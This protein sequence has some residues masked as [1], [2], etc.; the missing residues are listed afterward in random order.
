MVDQVRDRLRAKY[1]RHI[2]SRRSNNNQNGNNNNEEG[3][4]TASD[5]FKG[6]CNRCGKYGHKEFECRTKKKDH[7]QCYHCKEM[8]HYQ[9]ECPKKHN[10]NDQGSETAATAIQEEMVLVSFQKSDD[11]TGKPSPHTFLADSGASGHMINDDDGMY[12][13]KPVKINITIGD[14][15]QLTCTKIGNKKYTVKGREKDEVIVLKDV[16]FVPGLYVNLFS[17]GRALQHGWS[18]GNQGKVIFI[19]KDRN[20]IRFNKVYHTQTGFLNGIELEPLQKDGQQ[21]P[22]QEQQETQRSQQETG[23]LSEKG[24]K[25]PKI[26]LN[27]LHKTLDHVHKEVCK[28]TARYYGWELSA[29]DMEVCEPC[30]QAKAKQASLNKE[31]KTKAKQVG[32]RMCLDIQP[33]T[34]PSYGGAKNWLLVVDEK[35][36]FCWSFFIKTKDQTTKCV[37]PLLMD[38]RARNGITVKTIRCDNSGEN[39]ALLAECKAQG[40]GIQPEWTASGTPQQ[41]GKVERKLATLAGYARAMLNDA[42]IKGKMRHGL[43]AEAA[44]TAT[45]LNNILVKEEGRKSPHFQV[46]NSEAKYVNNLRQFGEL[47]VVTNRK[48]TIQ[49]KTENKGRTCM[50]V[51]YPSDSP[52]KTFRMFDFAKGSI[53][54]SRD[55]TWLNRTYSTWRWKLTH[56]EDEDNDDNNDEYTSP[57]SNEDNFESVDEPGDNSSDKK[58][59]ETD[60]I[61]PIQDKKETQQKGRKSNE[62]QLLEEQLKSSFHD[63][64][65]FHEQDNAPIASGTRKKQMTKLM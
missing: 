62:R 16:M 48:G 30:A 61:E 47:A 57:G 64:K 23:V 65:E 38:L 3:A 19:T 24:A 12:D 50:F 45:M 44:N 51:G 43:W 42:G 40:L 17:I 33:M 35:S 15:K 27:V 39:K 18:L 25:N 46:Y 41:N 53:I 36:D 8:G 31:T 26:K 6:R 11:E 56:Q 21:K 10:N 7:I 60:E 13:V 58:E 54:K 14:G 2:K 5:Q 63:F 37:A 4:L 34:L 55:V 9:N 20:T 49:N 29:K 52:S 28:R 32:E 22:S 1:E 59:E